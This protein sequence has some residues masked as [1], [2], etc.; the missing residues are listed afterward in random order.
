MLLFKARHFSP[1]D[2]KGYVVMGIQKF[3]FAVVAV[4]MLA[5][6]VHAVDPPPIDSHLFQSGELV[7]TDG[8][9]GPLNKKWWQTRTKNWEVV[10]GLLI[11][12]PDYK[13]VAEA[14][15]ALKRDHHLGLSPVIRLDNLP[16]KFVVRMRVK[17]EG[18]EFKT[19]RPKFDI[20]HHINTV[21]F[22][23]NGYVVKLHGGKQFLGKAPDV[24]LNEW[25]DVALEF[26]EGELWIEVNGKGQLIKHEQVVLEGRSELTFKTF[27][28]APNRIMFDSVSL[29]KA[30]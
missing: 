17:F 20:G 9:D 7:Y 6:R 26:Q 5:S 8:F 3:L 16:S 10:D 30:N 28:D 23:D 4:I 22:R 11:G 13:D 14:Q 21:T 19:G 24:K 15:T 25:L 27:E 1:N 29:W 2:K 18:K 12:A